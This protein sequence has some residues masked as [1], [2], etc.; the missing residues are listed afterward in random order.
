MAITNVGTLQDAVES[1][2]ER[3]LTDS[4][5]LEFANQVADKLNHGVMGPDGR[6]WL[7]PPVRIRS[8]LDTDTLTTSGGSVALPADWLETE[9]LWIDNSDG[10]GID[11]L[12]MPLTQF[13]THPDA[14][15]TGPPSKFT[16]D[17]STLYIAP[18]TD[19]DLEI[20]YY[21]RLGGFT[22]DSDTD[23]ILTNHPN[24]YLTGCIAQA[25]GWIGDYG[26]QDRENGNFYAAARALNANNSRAQSSGSL[27]VA[28][29]QAVS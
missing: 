12:Y 25:C 23:A 5:F 18:T 24:T 20:S 27:L 26:R 22:G 14:V 8:M 19:A 7:C 2:L 11:L 1:W 21:A 13:R 10:T 28:R 6:T 16:V 3:T 9:R 29:P 4:L 15:L 17:G